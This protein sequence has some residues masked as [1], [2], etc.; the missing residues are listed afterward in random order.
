MRQTVSDISNSEATGNN[1]LGNDNYINSDNTSNT[2]NSSNNKLYNILVVIFVFF[3]LL[4]SIISICLNSPRYSDLGFDYAGVVVAV[5]S[6]L[7]AILIGW[8]IFNMVNVEKRVDHIQREVSDV[9]DKID[10][11]LKNNR[12]DYDHEISG[13]L[14]HIYAINYILQNQYAN[15]FDCLNSGI[16]EQNKC[17]NPVYLNNILKLFYENLNY[18]EHIKISRVKMQGTIELLKKTHC[19]DIQCNGYKV[20]I[21]NTLETYLNY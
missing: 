11:K 7:I 16:V 14:Y 5:L 19:N 21:I 10:S 4:L 20:E 3:S 2:G 12:E 1:I 8:N 9:I 17:S 6:L 15:A 18:L 13:A